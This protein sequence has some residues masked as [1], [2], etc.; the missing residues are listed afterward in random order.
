[1]AIAETRE[2]RKTRIARNER[3]LHLGELREAAVSLLETA[4]QDDP[5][6]MKADAEFYRVYEACTCGAASDIESAA[7]WRVYTAA[8]A[9][10]RAWLR[11]RGT[12]PLAFPGAEL[13]ML[14][15]EADDD[16]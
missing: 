6:Y 9:M 11:D 2:D 14:R 1:M 4:Y 16:N 15:S 8:E 10:A 7:N 3:R 5:D 13:A 12:A